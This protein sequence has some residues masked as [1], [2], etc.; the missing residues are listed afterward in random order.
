MEADTKEGPG[1]EAV[2]PFTGPQASQCPEGCSFFPADGS[3]VSLWLFPLE[4]VRCFPSHPPSEPSSF[5]SLLT[6][7]F[8]FPM[9]PR[10]TAFQS[11]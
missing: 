11:N 6:Q 8:V 1:D 3:S 9:R 5:T 2:G 4:R 10:R 7:P